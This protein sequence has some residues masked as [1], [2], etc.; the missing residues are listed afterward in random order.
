MSGPARDLRERLPRPDPRLLARAAL[1]FVGALALWYVVRIPWTDSV[2]GGARPVLAAAIEEGE[3]KR[4]LK[5][6]DRVLIVSTGIP[7]PRGEG[8]MITVR[9]GG[10]DRVGWPVAFLFA[11]A[12]LTP[13][14]RL[15]RVWPWALGAL[16]AVWAVQ[17]AS[18]SVEVL[19]QV[20][21]QHAQRGLAFVGPR[22]GR[23]L[24]LC[25]D[26]LEL[27]TPIAPLAFY[28]P[29]FLVRADRPGSDDGRRSAVPRNSACPCGSGEKFKRCCGAS[30]AQA[31][32]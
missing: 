7:S 13:L 5:V 26:Y 18:L 32:G 3:G 28:L 10:I 2:I 17:V 31:S 27:M 16:A 25:G 1:A 22:V 15:K 21:A 4:V 20:A 24:T 9:N 29:V 12:V 30:A 14:S 23:A 19:Q 6:E 11:L 8:R